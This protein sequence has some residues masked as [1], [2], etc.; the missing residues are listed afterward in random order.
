VYDVIVIGAGISGATFACKASKFAKT[1]LIEAR[2][3]KNLAV[4][5]NVYAE[6]NKRFLHEVDYSDK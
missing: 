4:T 3:E 2:E 5:T 1:L 6:H